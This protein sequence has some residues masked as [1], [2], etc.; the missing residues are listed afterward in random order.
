MIFWSNLFIIH[1]Q[2]DA[3]TFFALL[4]GLASSQCAS[5][6]RKNGADFFDL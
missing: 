4:I 6:Q 5:E 1:K 3:P 2:S